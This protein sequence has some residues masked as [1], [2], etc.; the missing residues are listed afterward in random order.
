VT[1]LQL[2]LAPVFS[3]VRDDNA[4][5]ATRSFAR[6]RECTVFQVRTS[7]SSSLFA[8]FEVFVV[9]VAKRVV[10]FMSVAV[11]KTRR[12]FYEGR[13]GAFSANYT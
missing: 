6:V 9:F 13:R 2:S 10:C 11:P 7:G 12:V 4:T 8:F 3:V 1:F 5:P